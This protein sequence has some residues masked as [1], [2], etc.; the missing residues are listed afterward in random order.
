MKSISYYTYVIHILPIQIKLLSTKDTLMPKLIP[1]IYSVDIILKVNILNDCWLKLRN[2]LML[3]VVE[4][5]DD[6]ETWQEEMK[7]ENFWSL[8]S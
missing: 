8:L 7:Q 2:W 5:P 4:R 1:L 3:Y 6:A